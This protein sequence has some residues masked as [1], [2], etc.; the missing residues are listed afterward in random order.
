MKRQD[1]TLTCEQQGAYEQYA[2]THAKRYALVLNWLMPLMRPRARIFSIGSM[3]NQIEL[4]LMH[5]L[6]VAVIGSTYSPRD[7]RNRFIAVY[8]LADGKQYEIETYLCNFPHDPI[9]LESQSCDVVL[10]LEV[11]EHFQDS[12]L[13]LFR[14]I[15]H[16]L[17]PE[18]ALFISTPNSQHWHRLI[19]TINGLTYPDIDFDVPL[20]SRH[21]HIFSLRELDT[22]LRLAGFK[23]VHHFF[24]DV[25]DNAEHLKGTDL[26][27]PLNKALYEMLLAREECRHE[28]I[29]AEARPCERGNT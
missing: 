1:I 21:M 7:T 8:Q 19:Y 5:Y 6:D 10:C 15:K 4:L 20:E 28:C 25:W 3:P 27:E 17:R 26:N 23:I 16:I 22:L 2:R 13:E 9:P 12:P 29:F 14:K 11:L 24:A 18:G